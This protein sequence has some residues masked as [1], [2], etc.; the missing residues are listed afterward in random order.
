MATYYKMGYEGIAYYGVAGATG[1]TQI[2]N[3]VDITY[4]MNQNTA[5]TMVRGTGSAPPIMTESV[6]ARLAE[7][8]ITM[9][10]YASDTVLE[11]IRS[12]CS[13]ATPVAI[14]LKDHAA[15][16]GFDGDC[17]VA[18]SQPWPLGDT[19]VVTVT[20]KPTRDGGREPSLY[21]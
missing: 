9:K 18:V 12:A 13:T 11:A 2:T 4:S 6:T 3:A 10:N 8:E 1:A 15:G 17:H 16:K 20:C 21:V 19:Q 5:D 7:I 14:R